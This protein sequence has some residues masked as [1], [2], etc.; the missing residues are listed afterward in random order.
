M[1]VNIFHLLELVDNNS[2]NLSSSFLTKG[3]DFY[4]PVLPMKLGRTLP[5]DPQHQENRFFTLSH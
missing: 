1:T 3:V 2:N 5:F 4:R